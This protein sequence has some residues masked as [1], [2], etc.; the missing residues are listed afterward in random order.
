MQVEEYNNLRSYIDNIN[1]YL[2]NSYKDIFDYPQTNVAKSVEVI[3]GRLAN[4]YIINADGGLIKS[5]TF[6][7]Y[8]FD[9]DSL[10][11]YN[12]DFLHLERLD[13][14]PINIKYSIDGDITSRF[15][16]AYTM[17]RMYNFLFQKRNI[18]LK[19]HDYAYVLTYYKS[20]DLFEI[21][22]VF[23]SE[24][25]LSQIDLNMLD[26]QNQTKKVIVSINCSNSLIDF[27]AVRNLYN[28]LLKNLNE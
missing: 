6:K 9:F 24:L 18:N 3:T 19:Q 12:V 14:Y 4:A 28:S 20:D 22:Y 7:L 15:E 27:E 1:D 11:K 10:E 16:A 2:F 8:N 21:D 13:Y 23:D 17:N 25:N 5:A 26:K